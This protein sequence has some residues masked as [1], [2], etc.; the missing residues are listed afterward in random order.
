ME[1]TLPV[2]STLAEASK[3][4]GVLGYHQLGLLV[5]LNGETVEIPTLC[6]SVRGSQPRVS[7]ARTHKY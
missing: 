3:V 4:A 5:I 1:Q 2:E 6:Q 7:L